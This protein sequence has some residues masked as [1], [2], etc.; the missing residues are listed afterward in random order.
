MLLAM[1]ACSD[2]GCYEE[3]EVAVGDLEEL[4]GLVC[5][6]GHGFV[7]ISV[8]ELREPGRAVVALAPRRSGPARRPDR[9]AA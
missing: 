4:D 5:E 7:L 3:R 2:P 1:L 6:C 9:R 8:S